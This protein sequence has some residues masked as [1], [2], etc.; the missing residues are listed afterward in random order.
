MNRRIFLCA[1]DCAPLA[2]AAARRHTEVSIQNDQFFING[3]P[4][5]AGRSYKGLKIE[6]LLM[7]MRVGQGT[8]DDLNPATRVKWSYPD[9]GKWDAERNMREFQAAMPEW[10]RHG[11]LA[12]TLNLHVSWSSRKDA[13]DQ[14]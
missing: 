7:N 13:S 2:Q 3:K 10:R 8:F 1:A 14:R 9:T 12:F 6:G 11:L 4:T 5:Y